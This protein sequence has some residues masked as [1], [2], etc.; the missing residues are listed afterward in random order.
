MAVAELAVCP[1]AQMQWGHKWRSSNFSLV[2][3]NTD[4]QNAWS[5]LKA[6]L[7]NNE[8]AQE[9]CRRIATLSFTGEHTVRSLWWPTYVNTIA[10]LI[11]RLL[12]A[13]GNEIPSVREEFEEE[14]AKF[15]R[16]YR[17]LDESEWDPRIQPF[18]D[19]M[20]GLKHAFSVMQ[21]IPLQ[22]D[23]GEASEKLHLVGQ[24]LTIRELGAIAIL[25]VGD[26]A[27]DQEIQ[28]QVRRLTQAGIEAGERGRLKLTRVEGL[29]EIEWVSLS[30]VGGRNAIHSKDKIIIFSNEL[31]TKVT[32]YVIEDGNRLRKVKPLGQ[33]EP[34]TVF[35]PYALS[36][37]VGAIDAACADIDSIP[38]MAQRPSSEQGDV[39][40][41]DGPV[42]DAREELRLERESF[43]LEDAMAYLRN[44]TSAFSSAFVG[45]GAG[46]GAIGTFKTRRFKPKWRLCRGAAHTA[47]DVEISHGCD[48]PGKLLRVR[49]SVVTL[50]FSTSH[51]AAMYRFLNSR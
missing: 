40:A 28:E 48:V 42:F 50:G 38:M 17:I 23:L 26:S 46:I 49:S 35:T 11:S 10:D 5:W 25:E 44:D 34:S 7:A 30:T 43:T 45:V 16:P 13:D 1:I 41:A 8:L 21:N 37:V 14:N 29:P 4:N 22:S 6:M 12:D 27:A 36:K 32:E 18:I 31:V 39:G 15:V 9:I 24:T 3:F 19:W 20:G 51:H 2:L 47:R 33:K